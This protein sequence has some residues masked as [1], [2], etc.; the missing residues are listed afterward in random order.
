MTSI[1]TLAKGDNYTPHQ[2]LLTKS[3]D[4]MLKR[5]DDYTLE[6]IGNGYYTL[7]T[8]DLSMTL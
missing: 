8:S 1:D 5:Y 3:H 2:Y 6:P 4:G 7:E